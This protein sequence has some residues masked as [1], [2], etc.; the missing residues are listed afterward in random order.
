MTS[1]VTPHLFNTIG[2][3]ASEQSMWRPLSRESG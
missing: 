1:S 2:H 3:P